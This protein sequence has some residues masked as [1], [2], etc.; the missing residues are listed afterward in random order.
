MSDLFPKWTNQ[1][2]GMVITAALVIG[3]TVTAGTWYYFTPKSGRTGYQPRQP[4]A[5]SHEIHASQL[6][7]DCRYCHSAVERSWFSNVPAS[8]TCMN[9]HSLILKDSPKL[10][11]VRESFRTGQ[12]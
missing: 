6:G 4:V 10:E 12:P 3:V 9:C 2:P 5:F 11:L 1:L 8:A 7:I